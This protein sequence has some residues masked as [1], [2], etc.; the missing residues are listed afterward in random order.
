M[1]IIVSTNGRNA[2]KVEETGVENED[3]LQRYVFDNP[4]SLPVDQIKEGA[5]LLVV[6]REFETASGPIDVL[7]LDRDGDVYIIE[8]KLFQNPD[9]RRVV[10]QVLDYGAALWLDLGT[11]DFVRVMDEVVARQSQVGLR[12]RMAETYGCSDDEASAALEM[13]KANVRDGNF[14]FVVLMDQLH[15]GL[16]RLLQFLNA[17]SRFTVYA[18][19]MEFYR[20]ESMEIVIPRL[21]GAEARKETG[22][23]RTPGK[24]KGWNEATYFEDVGRRLAEEH[25]AAIRNL[26][27]FSAR[28]ADEWY[29]GKGTNRGSFNPRYWSLGPLALFTA[30]SD[31]TLTMNFKTL[32]ADGPGRTFTRQLKDALNAAGFGPFPDDFENRYVD[33]PIEIWASRV[34]VFEEIVSELRTRAAQPASG[35]VPE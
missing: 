4:E 13:V 14:K 9:K 7:A 11:D 22:W 32:T 17:K 20:H 27:D 24:T 33:I 15:A 2:R 19:E 23:S 8:T 18:V 3:F 31:G 25:A 10:A 30:Y 26:F 1:A 21:F 34:N 28:T 29:W 12:Q 6:A 35:P 16:K 5:R